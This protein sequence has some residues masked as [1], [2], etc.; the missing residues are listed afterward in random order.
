MGIVEVE[1]NSDGAV[2]QITS[3]KCGMQV[4]WQTHAPSRPFSTN[5]V[6]FEVLLQFRIHGANCVNGTNGVHRVD[7]DAD[8]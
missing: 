3:L 8:G 1:A 7:A 2:V 5:S 6:D 4:Q